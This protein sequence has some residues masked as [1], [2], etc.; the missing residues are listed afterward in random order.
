MQNLMHECIK[1]IIASMKSVSGKAILSNEVLLNIGF[2]VVLFVCLRTSTDILLEGPAEI[3][4]VSITED[5]A[6]L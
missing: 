2:L 1:N 4:Q 3:P 6:D 5:I